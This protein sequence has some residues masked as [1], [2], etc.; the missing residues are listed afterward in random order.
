MRAA[1]LDRFGGPEVLTLHRLLVPVPDAGEI[2]LKI[3]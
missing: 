2:V 3:R 1:A